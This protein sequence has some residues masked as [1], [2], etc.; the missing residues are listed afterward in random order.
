MLRGGSKTS[1]EYYTDTDINNILDAL[2]TKEYNLIA[3]H[4]ALASATSFNY[5][6]NAN[7]LDDMHSF[8]SINNNPVGGIIYGYGSNSIFNLPQLNVSQDHHTY[9]KEA[10]EIIRSSRRLLVL[11]PS[12]SIRETMTQ[13]LKF[14][15]NTLEKVGD[16]YGINFSYNTFIS[17][18]YNNIC[19]WFPDNTNDIQ[20]LN[21]FEATESLQS[22]LRTL[23]NSVKLPSSEG[24]QTVEDDET[25]TGFI[26]S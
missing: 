8:I 4:E 6:N 2:T 13:P 12:V 26:H 23:G 22:K 10:S 3:T 17:K 15:K 18:D 11:K 9:L 19:I 5:M 20:Y 21:V 1:L 24:P 25:M 14:T 16:E 7:L